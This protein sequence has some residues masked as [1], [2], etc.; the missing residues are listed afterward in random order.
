[1]KIYLV[2]GAV[3]DKLLGL[4]VHDRDYCVT[5]ATTE[6]MLKLGY[7]CVGKDFPVFIHPKTRE[8]YALARTERKSGHGYTG[9]IC[10]FSKEVTIE[11]DLERR[12][13]TINAIAMDD[14]NQLI[15]PFGGYQD[16]QNRILR[17]VSL[18]FGEDPLRVLRLAR[19]YAKLKD[20]GFTIASET[21]E[22][23]KQMVNEGELAH[24]T[25]ERIW[26]ETEK[27]L[28]TKHPEAYFEFLQQCGA[29]AVIMPELDVL[30]TVPENLVYHP[31]GNVFDHTM[32]T[33]KEICKLTK[34]PIT[35]FAMV[36]HDFGKAL[37]PSDKWPSHEQHKELGVDVIKKMCK[38]LRVPCEYTNTAMAVCSCHSYLTLYKKD[39]SVIEETFRKMNGY[40]NPYNIG[41]LAQCLSADYRGRNLNVPAIFMEPFN[42]LFMFSKV[43]QIDVQDIIKQ[44]YQ[45]AEISQKL[46]EKRLE[47]IKQAQNIL[48][49]TYGPQTG[50]YQ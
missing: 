8:E 28:K 15:D 12:D 49:T 19:F 20:L 3:R 29:L 32:L 38:R 13:L 46:K 33:I 50:D 27:A 7:Q 44:G 2:G 16:L 48:Q 45:G 25:S 31:E 17:H 40:R 11:E 36:T 35:R 5:G 43:C 21:T 37:T 22:L 23:C 39:P 1:M 47:I 34:S 42:I 9:F 14:N 10:S 6:E 26:T 18:A 24:L 30:K 41:I 4:K